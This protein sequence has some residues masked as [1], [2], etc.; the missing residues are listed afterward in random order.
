LNFYKPVDVEKNTF[1]DDAKRLSQVCESLISNKSIVA[2]QTRTFLTPV[3]IIKV[4]N[5]ISTNKLGSTFKNIILNSII[6]AFEG[7][8]TLRSHMT[9]WVT[10]ISL[11][12]DRWDYSLTDISKFSRRANDLEL[13]DIV[14]KY[15][16]VEECLD[17]FKNVISMA[18]SDS[19]ISIEESKFEKT[20]VIQSPGFKMPFTL[21][22]EFWRAV[23]NKK[24][25]VLEPKIALIDGTITTIGEIHGILNQSHMSNVPILIFA[26]GFGEE[27]IGTLIQNYKMGKLKV[28]PVI[29]PLG[30]VSNIIYDFSE[31]IDGDVVS[32]INGAKV[33]SI[34]LDELKSISLA[35]IDSQNLTVFL[36]NKNNVNIITQKLREEFAEAAKKHEDYSRDIEQSYRIR[37]NFLTN[38]R[39]EILI[40][41][42]SESQQ[43]MLKDRLQTI[44]SIYNEIVETGII[45][46]HNL[47]DIIPNTLYDKLCK[48]GIKFV[49]SASFCFAMS[50]AKANRKLLLGSKKILIIDT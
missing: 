24:I 10:A 6:N 39:I 8:N 5:E 49:P 37:L 28:F 30:P 50:S 46:V 20:R 18:G 26:R 9:A 38:K 12:E 7:G 19:S 14:E 42:N 41:K 1:R 23:V 33:S 15:C 35:K 36:K 32:V 29:L 3:D 27:V 13:F 25:E 2:A 21:P 45:D 31:L 17:I 11:L 48:F 4:R 40:G 16:N 44:F 34:K 22:L 47:K 43:G